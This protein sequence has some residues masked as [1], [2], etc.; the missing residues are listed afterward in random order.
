M[1]DEEFMELFHRNKAV[2][3]SYLRLTPVL[4]G[5]KGRLNF[6][7]KIQ[8]PDILINTNSG[9]VEVGEHCMFGYG[10]MLITGVHDYTKFGDERRTAVPSEGHDIVLEEGVWLASG[11]IV[12]GPARI[13]KHSV[14]A[15]GSLVRSDIP[16]YGIYA[17]SPAKKVGDLTPPKA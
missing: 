11:V 17:G 16:A 10:V 5:P 1:T 15:A 6:K 4:L 12:L 13:G 9:T 2:I 7:S 3:A 14:V 8:P